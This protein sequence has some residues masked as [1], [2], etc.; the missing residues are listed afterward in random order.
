[1][2]SAASRPPTKAAAIA[3]AFL[4]LLAVATERATAHDFW[5]E[6]EHFRTRVGSTVTL[7]CFI[8][9]GDDLSVYPRNPRHIRRFV[10][11]GPKGER[12]VPGRPGGDAGTL[13]FDEPGLHLLAY[14][15]RPSITTLAADKFAAYLEEEGLVE[16]LAV[17]R[18][19]ASTQHVRE[20][21]SR[22][23]KSLVAVGDEPTGRFDRVLDLPLE[24]VP[25]ADPITHPHGTPLP[26][27][28]L[29]S[30]KALPKTRVAA[31]RRDAPHVVVDG[32]TDAEGRIALPLDTPG[33]WIVKSVHI[34]K[35]RGTLDW[36]ST[37]AT[38]TFERPPRPAE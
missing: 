18:A 29:R 13:T 19:D 26:F 5:V 10:S 37:W 27:R 7:R 24:I 3:A 11:V 35:A 30:G 9:H 36:Q 34:R 8:G 4:L 1:M 20:A 2:P 28:L 6:P 25:E 31:Y 23:A 38:L 16:A 14:E 17:H 22:C 15:S 33:M 12:E 32:H 21:F